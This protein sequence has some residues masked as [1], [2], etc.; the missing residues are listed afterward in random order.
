LSPSGKLRVFFIASEADPLVKI[1]GLGDVAGSLPAALS[2]LP[3]AEFGERSLDIRVAIPFYPGLTTGKW[4]PKLA[5]QFDLTTPTGNIPVKVYTIKLKGIWIYL[6]D[7]EPVSR[8]QGVYSLNTVEDGDKFIFFSLA[9]LE[10]CKTMKWK[11]DILHANDW[12]TA[13]SVYRLAEQRT[14]DPFFAKTR[15]ILSLHNLPFMGAGTRPSLDHF[16]ILPSTDPT[17]PPWGRELPLPMGLSVADAIVAVSPQYGK[18]ILTPE[19]G[20]DLQEF[21]ATRKSKLSGI[22]NGLDTTL[23]DP[24]HDPT[25]RA[26]FSV[27]DL[28]GKAEDK[29]AVWEEFNLSGDAAKLPLFVL[30]SRM[31]RQKGIDLALEGLRNMLQAGKDLQWRAILLGSGDPSL[32]TQSATLAFDFPD[33]VRAVK[34]FDSQ[35]SHRLYA[36]ADI[37]MMPSRYEACGLSQMIAMRYGCLP[38]ARATGGL[39][40]T[41]QD[42]KTGFLF[43]PV[44]AAAFQNALERALALYQL[45][46]KW[47]TMQKNAMLEDFSWHNSARQY[48]GLYTALI[49]EGKNFLKR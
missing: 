2:S 7:G 31:D 35:L 43:K 17:L 4:N 45:P 3:A 42:G 37:L 30:I 8:N 36:G 5:S 13:L 46:K 22:L 32:E 9:C 24:A 11:P 21:L 20:C 48:A 47:L 6:L 44:E 1:G 39:V 12:H 41:I 26:S 34:R 16:G 23:W 28:G 18:E 49:D 38:V 10:L 14:N 27:E 29:K 40:D 19:Y 33:Q 15:T 25:I